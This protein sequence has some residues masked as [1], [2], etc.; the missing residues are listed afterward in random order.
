M[1]YNTYYLNCKQTSIAAIHLCF[2]GYVPASPVVVCVTVNECLPEDGR[3]RP[4][5]LGGLPHVAY[6]CI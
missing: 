6:H 2:Q 4:K 1:Y 5:Y 3:E